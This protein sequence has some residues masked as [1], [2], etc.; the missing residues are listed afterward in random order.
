MSEETILELLEDLD[1]NKARGLENLSAKLLKD[2]ASVLAKPI[3]QTR[4]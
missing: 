4:S 2:G 1:E 3:F